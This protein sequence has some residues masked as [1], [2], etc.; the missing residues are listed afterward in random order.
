MPR[1]ATRCFSA[2]TALAASMAL[3]AG[4][5]AHAADFFPDNTMIGVGP[6]FV[7]EYEGSNDYRLIP[8]V[9]AQARWG[10]KYFIGTDGGGVRADV[11]GSRFI[12]FGPEVNFRFSRGANASDPVI[13]ALPRVDSSI[14][15]GGFLALNF[16]FIL[17][18]NPKD[19]LTID[20]NFLTDVG[21]G[22]G[23]ETSRVAIM[24]RG[25][26]TPK[27]VLQVGP[28]ATHASDSF[29]SAY[30]SVTAAGSLASG[31]PVFDAQAGWK[32]IGARGS[33]QYRFTDHWGVTG[34]I[35]Y[36]HYVNGAADSPIVSLR[37]SPGIW[38]GGMAL[39]YTF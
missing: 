6:G 23:G 20:L 5:P 29:M 17:S 21:G 28:F 39:T 4:S 10:G 1:H 15:L 34:S 36:R 25:L 19:A 12:E 24:Y 33:A 14:E 37:G 11:I 7:Q 8:F 9:V 38:L 16:P 26:V 35:T 3:A 2:G 27:L 22:H 18:K 31:L 32:D 13:A 30:Y